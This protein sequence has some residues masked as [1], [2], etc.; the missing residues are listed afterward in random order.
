MTFLWRFGALLLICVGLMTKSW[1]DNWANELVNLTGTSIILDEAGV[2][3][4]LKQA[5]SPD[6]NQLLELSNYKAWAGSRLWVVQFN[7]HQIQP[8]RVST[9]LQTQANQRGIILLDTLKTTT[10]PLLTTA[11]SQYQ[12]APQQL[13]ELL[14]QQQSDGLLLI[15]TQNQR[16]YWQIFSPHFKISGDI[17]QEG[18]DYLPHIWA[19]HLGMIW[20]WPELDEG[21]LIRVENISSLQQFIDAENTLQNACPKLQVLQVIGT[22]TNFACLGKP[23]YQQLVTQLKLSPQLSLIPFAHPQ[24]SPAVLIGQELSQRYLHYQWHNDTY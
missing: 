3:D 10:I 13:N 2:Q 24:L 5:P 18:T 7:Q 22:Q 19:E 14:N 1:A 23:S 6:L 12:Q 15:S 16:I 20:Q 17:S 11:I 8:Y 4:S 21:I 9:D